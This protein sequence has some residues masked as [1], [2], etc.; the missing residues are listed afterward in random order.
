MNRALDSFHFVFGFDRRIDRPIDRVTYRVACT[1]LES[2]IE[3]Q[4][5][6]SALL[7]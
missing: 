6:F 5:S 4:M 7:K 2:A 3:I 1:R